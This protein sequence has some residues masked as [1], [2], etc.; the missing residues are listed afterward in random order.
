MARD[1][2]TQEYARTSAHEVDLGFVS[3]VGGATTVVINTALSKIK[4]ATFGCADTGA[5]TDLPFTI[6]SP[7]ISAD[8]FAPTNGTITV[9]R[10]A[11]TT[12][13]MKLMY[14]LEGN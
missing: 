11:G 10:A 12:A 1:T 13:N 6:T 7:T 2:K 3:F 14:R 9:T 8:G 5:N 4:F